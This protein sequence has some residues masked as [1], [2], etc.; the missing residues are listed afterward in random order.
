MSIHHCIKKH[1][2]LNSLVVRLSPGVK[3]MDAVAFGFG[4]CIKIH[5]KMQIKLVSV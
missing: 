2:L 5:L 1:M 4:R 3:N